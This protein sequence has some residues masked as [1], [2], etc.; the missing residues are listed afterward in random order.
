MADLNMKMTDPIFRTQYRVIYGDTD[1]GG[2]MY[3]A[4]YL[5]LME[6]GRTE[7]LRSWAIPYSEMEKQG[8]ILPVTESYLRYKA[9]A[10]YDDLVTIAT[11][12]AELKHVSCRFHYRISRWEEGQGQERLLVKGFTQL[13]CINRQGKLTPFPVNIQEAMQGIWQQVS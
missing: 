8:L 12:L 13:A 1:S 2:I 3:H 4:N 10:R 5:R 9:P 11:S 7:M 6:I